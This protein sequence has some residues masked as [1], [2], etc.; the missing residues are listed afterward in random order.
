MGEGETVVSKSVQ[1]LL[2]QQCSSGRPQLQE[3]VGHKIIPDVFKT[4]KERKL[5]GEGIGSG[6][7]KMWTNMTK[8]H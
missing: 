7:G 6:S 5:A 8:I 2:S 3:F 1:P 4:K